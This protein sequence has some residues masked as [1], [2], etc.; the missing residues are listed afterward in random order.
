MPARQQMIGGEPRGRAVAGCHAVEAHPG[1]VAVHQHGGQ[2]GGMNERQNLGLVDGEQDDGGRAVL[3]QHRRQCFGL[4][5]TQGDRA[6]LEA[7]RR[8][9]LAHAGQDL[10]GE[11]VAVVVG[12]RGPAGRHQHRLA[13][14]AAGQRIADLARRLDQ[15]A[16]QLGTYAGLA[17]EGPRRGAH[18]HAV[19]FRQL[20]E[21]HSSH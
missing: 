18:R 8:C 7:Q 12:D 20:V 3:G 16:P 2:P 1:I 15:I 21:P 19:P 13:L 6:Q 10:G 14:Q 17:R 5:V 11:Q 9:A 4:A